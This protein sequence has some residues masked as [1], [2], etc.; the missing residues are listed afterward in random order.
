MP[1][2]V[3]STPAELLTKVPVATLMKQGDLRL[4]GDRLSFI[5]HSGEVVLDAPVDEIHSVV[6]A[7]TGIHVW[8]NTR[9]LRFAFKANRALAA[10][11]VATLTPLM[12]TPPEG[13]RVPAP[14]PRWMWMLAVVGGTA[15]LVMLVIA[16]T[17]INN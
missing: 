7:A 17:K 6:P 1:A 5:T 10:T 12:G 8:H 11:W 3:L 4:A 9:C 16:L 15:V 13:L 14:W 2:A